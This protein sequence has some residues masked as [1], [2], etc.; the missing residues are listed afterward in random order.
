MT[1]VSLVLIQFFNAYN[2]RSDRLSVVRAAVRQPVAEPRDRVGAGA[3]GRDHL[4]AVLSAGVRHV[5]SVRRP[6]GC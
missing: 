1:F 2:C 4:R 5:Q 3:A 6:T